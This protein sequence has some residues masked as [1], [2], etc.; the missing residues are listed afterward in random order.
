QSLFWGLLSA[1]SVFIFK[2]YSRPAFLLVALSAWS[3]LL[4]ALKSHLGPA[5]L[6]VAPLTS[7]LIEKPYLLQGLSLWGLIGMEAFIYAVNIWLALLI[8]KKSSSPL[9]KWGILT[10]FLVYLSFSLFA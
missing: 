7:F 9:F 6:P 3:A 2:R 4:F 8:F 5:S 10:L 1:G